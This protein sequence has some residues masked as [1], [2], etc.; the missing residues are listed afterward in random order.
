M[1]RLT[2]STRALLLC[3]E[4]PDSPR[5]RAAKEWLQKL[6]NQGPADL[7]YYTARSLAKAGCLSPALRSQLAANQAADGSF[8]NPAGEMREDCPVVATA[9]MTEALAT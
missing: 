1:E 2:R 4:S 3:G 5:A 6:P 7:K 8:R 9:L